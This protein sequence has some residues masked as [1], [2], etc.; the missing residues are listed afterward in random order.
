MVLDLICA[1]KPL[2]VLNYCVSE[3]VCLS[4]SDQQPWICKTLLVNYYYRTDCAQILVQI[5]GI[6]SLGSKVCGSGIHFTRILAIHNS[7]KMLMCV[8]H[9]SWASVQLYFTRTTKEKTYGCM[10][11]SLNIKATSQLSYWI[12]CSSHL[13]LWRQ[14]ASA[15]CDVRPP[16]PPATSERQCPLWRQNTSAIGDVRAPVPTVTSQR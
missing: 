8:D 16:V 11:C 7:N 2:H 6:R 10:N 3:R 9:T 1:W 5:C 13:C 4:L 12:S 14:S 15:L